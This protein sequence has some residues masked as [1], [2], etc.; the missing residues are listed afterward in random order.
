MRTIIIDDEPDSVGLLQ[1]RLKQHFPQV[2]I[3]A[4]FT[5]SVEALRSLEGLR[6][7]LVFLD[8]EMPV[9][10]GFEL[11]SQLTRTDF[12]IIFVTAYNQ[13]AIRAFKF[14]ALDYLVKPV[15][16]EDL[17]LAISKAEAQQRIRAEQVGYLY[18]QMQQGSITKIAVPGNNGVVFIDFNDIIC[19]EANSNYSTLILTDNKKV[20]VAK[21]LKDVQEVMEQQHFLRVH[22]Q[23]IINLNQVKSFSRNEGLITLSNN[24]SIPV[25]RNQKDV[26][27]SKYGWL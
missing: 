25:S 18:Q 24:I 2:H 23:Y 26:F 3:V 11:L 16:I 12:S 15:N 27:M 14:N 13:F 4:T 7:Q 5:S 8:I 9:M 1:L 22:R 17:A 10:N 19:I 21:T 6:P 20:L